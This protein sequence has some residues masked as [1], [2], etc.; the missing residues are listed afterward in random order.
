MIYDPKALR[1][2]EMSCA[3]GC[4]R[5]LASGDPIITESDSEPG[6]EKYWHR[7]CLER[8]IDMRAA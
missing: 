4:G 2:I 5:A 3:A 6:V 7:A 1:T 8:H